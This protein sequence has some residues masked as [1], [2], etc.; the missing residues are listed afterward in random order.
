[1]PACPHIHPHLPTRITRTHTCLPSPTPI[2]LP[3][4]HYDHPPTPAPSPTPCTPNHHDHAPLAAPQQYQVS[5]DHTTH[6]LDDVPATSDHIDLTTTCQVTPAAVPTRVNIH[7]SALNKGGSGDPGMR[8]AVDCTTRGQ[9]VSGIYTRNHSRY[10]KGTSVCFLTS[11]ILPYSPL[12]SICTFPIP[13]HHLQGP[14]SKADDFHTHNQTTFQKSTH[15]LSSTSCVPL[16]LYL[17][18]IG[19]ASDALGPVR[20]TLRHPPPS[21]GHPFMGGLV[22]GGLVL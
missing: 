10:C 20:M 12:L 11:P 15:R 19:L 17:S 9:V 5:P 6:N 2:L 22:I 13:L 1:M 18:C 7:A 21:W 14:H 16:C 4:D 3:P 8:S